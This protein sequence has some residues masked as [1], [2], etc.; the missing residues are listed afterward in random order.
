MKQ[1]LLTGVAL[2][3]IVAGTGGAFAQT[4]VKQGSAN[5]AITNNADVTNSQ[6]NSTV[7]GAPNTQSS[8]SFT[9][10]AAVGS[11]AAVS[12]SGAVAGASV[13]AV[14]T[15]FNGPDLGF[16]AVTQYSL[17][18]GAI[19]NTS[20]GIS[21]HA[22]AGTLAA[23]SSAS[24]SATGAAA[25][26]GVSAINVG[27]STN[28]VA[29]PVVGNAGANIQQVTNQGAVANDKATLSLWTLSPVPARISR[30]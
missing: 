28:T 17:N 12:A 30:P 10:N 9:G 4:V 14:S 24:V 8:I 6:T 22:T 1:S 3:A 25:S 23:G 5:A 19:T 7:P 11:S 26:L 13:S 2:A 29:V 18:T 16:D 27:S 15:G 20:A 21:G